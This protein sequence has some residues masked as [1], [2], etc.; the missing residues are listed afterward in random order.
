MTNNDWYEGALAGAF[1]VM[2]CVTLNLAS[3]KPVRPISKV[4]QGFIAPSTLEIKCEDL[5][6]NGE[7]ETQLK[8]EDK[9][10]LLREVNGEPVLSAYEVNMQYK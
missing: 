1:A 7:P 3:H 6:G 8:I 5:D 2:V 10:Y 4:Q 9:T